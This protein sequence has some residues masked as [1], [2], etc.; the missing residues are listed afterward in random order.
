MNGQRDEHSEPA[1][2]RRTEES[3]SR[4]GGSI[5]QPLGFVVLASVA[6]LAL[7]ESL[8]GCNERPTASGHEEPTP[9]RPPDL[10]RIKSEHEKLRDAMRWVG[11]ADDIPRQSTPHQRLSESVMHGL[12]IMMTD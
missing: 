8:T 1:R 5:W 7:A 9:W 10:P 3:R 2:L 6:V 12:R 11:W 4:E